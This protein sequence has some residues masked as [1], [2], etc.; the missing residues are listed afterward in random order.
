[1][2]HML[3]TTIDPTLSLPIVMFSV[4][5][6]TIFWDPTDM[7]IIPGSGRWCLLLGTHT[8]TEPPAG[9]FTTECYTFVMITILI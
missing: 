5:K 2:Y 6:G 9:L 3:I 7:L 1:M 8:V 4:N